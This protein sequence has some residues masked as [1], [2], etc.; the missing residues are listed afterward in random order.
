LDHSVNLLGVAVAAADATR[1][2]LA[3]SQVALAALQAE[4]GLTE[5]RYENVREKNKTTIL[6]AFI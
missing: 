3:Q 4:R 6:F 2:T 5:T 1:S